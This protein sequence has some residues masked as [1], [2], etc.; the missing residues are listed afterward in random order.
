V[1][2]APAPLPSEPPAGSPHGLFVGRERELAE[3]AGALDAARTGRGGLYL[4]SGEPGIGKTRLAERCADVAAARGFAVLWGRCWESGGAPTYWPWVQVLRGAV[5]G[6]NAP[7]LLQA[8]SRIVAH[9]GQFV[10]E[11]APDLPASGWAPDLPFDTPE[12][13]RVVL[14]DAVQ[15]VLATLASERPLLVILDDLHAADESSL[16]LLQYL[17]RELQQSAALILAT[18]RDWEM[19]RAPAMRRL[20]GGL[21]RTSQHLPLHGL[22]E[23]EVARFMEAGARG[24]VQPRSLVSA[25]HR[26]TGGNPFFLQEVV[27]LLETRGHYEAPPQPVDEPLGVPLRVRETVRRRLESLSGR[28]SAMLPVAAVVGHEF[29]RV[30][31]GQVCGV[32][33]EP[34]L[35]LLDEAVGAGVLV[36]L[37]GHRYKFSH[38]IIREALC[39]AIPAG[40]RARVHARVGEVLESRSPSDPD[41]HLVELAHHF[42]EAAQGGADPAKAVTYARRAAQHALQRLAFEEA[43]AQFQ[44]ALLAFDLDP[45][46]ELSVRAELLLS[47]GAAQRRAGEADAARETFAHAAALARRLCSADML[48]RAALGFGGIGRERISVDH[49]WIALLEEAL[50]ALRDR[51]STLRARVQ[52]CLAMALYWSDG[53][54]RRDAL[55]RDAVAMARRLGDTATL[56]FALDFRLKAVWRPGGVEERLATADEILSLA[57]PNGDRHLELEAR[58]WK[59]VSLLERGDVVAADREIAAVTRIAEEMR[60]PLYRWQSLVWRAMRA[61]LDGAFARAEEFA[62]EAL[63][64]GE[65]VQSHVSTPVYLGQL[66]G[67]RWLQGR[68][69]ELTDALRALVDEGVTAPAYRVG[70]AQAAAQRGDITLA[71]RELDFLA[72]GGF[73]ILP[74][75]SARLS[76]LVALAEVVAA[77]EASEHAET[78]YEE[79]LPYA[80]LN[81]VLGPALGSFGAASRYLGVLAA[82]A[83]R[84]DDA[85]R[86]LTDA[87]ELNLRMGARG[88]L[89]CTQ[90]DLAAVLLRRGASGD[91]ERA[92]DLRD[93]AMETAEALD[94]PVLRGQ[95][96]ALA[97]LTPAPVAPA[98]ASTLSCRLVHEGDFWTVSFD[99]TTSRVRDAKGMRYLRVLLARP[100]QEFHVLALVADIEGARDGSPS[101]VRMSDATLE[102]LGMHRSAADD[103]GLVLDAQ[104]RASYR[105]RLAD[106]EAEREEAEAANDPG[107]RDRAAAEL[108]FLE[109]ELASAVGL[110]GRLRRAGSPAE[111]ARVS[112]TRAL[113][114]AIAR[115][116]KADPALGRHLDSTVR[117]G[118]FCSYAPDPRVPASWE[119]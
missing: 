111:R 10:P 25:V 1:E 66:F 106:L 114:A 2:K 75:D 12:Q 64:A 65:R 79:L 47:L 57:L 37:G 80:R 26:T 18:H 74:H 77:V 30:V 58:R 95:L 105:R 85:E 117:T 34:L 62:G 4:L 89:A 11:L 46:G 84:L 24:A 110:G 81:V 90:A 63:A 15:T 39:D 14:F 17:A 86:H 99:G 48:A 101:P 35:S 102:H 51:D 9:L 83:G 54:E 100:G 82:A 40:E 33:S 5:Q 59:V 70:L 44:R 36:H 13:A 91:A 73:A 56:A 20:L 68:L 53:P 88:W 112:V 6:C 7:A 16:L 104:A 109:R 27:R 61:G 3:L 78:L 19:H 94:M 98:A 96:R 60:D 32:S 76:I 42:G 45:Q 67:L 72:A 71:R 50:V 8:A 29:D 21:A 115:M 43:V 31:L 87:L 93:S 28:C 22:A 55:S 92:A 52:A 107:R 118:T 41:A 103:S 23:P 69:G 108:E 49:D 119:L 116:A 38:G 97:A 113:R